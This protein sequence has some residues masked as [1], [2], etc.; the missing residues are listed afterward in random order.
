MHWNLLFGSIDVPPDVS[1]LFIVGGG[2]QRCFQP[3]KI[4]PDGFKFTVH[5][6][7]FNAEA[8]SFVEL[9]YFIAAAIMFPWLLGNIATVP[10]K[11]ES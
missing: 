9:N 7:E 4:A 5:N 11:A 8:T 3:T 6:E 1:V 2:L 10:P